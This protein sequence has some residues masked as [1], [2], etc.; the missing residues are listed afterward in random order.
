MMNLITYYFTT[1][2]VK[3]LKLKNINNYKTV[4]YNKFIFEKTTDCS[5]LI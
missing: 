3:Y 1:I 5:L 4:S 2:Y